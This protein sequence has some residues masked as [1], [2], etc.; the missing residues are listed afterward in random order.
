MN[1]QILEQYRRRAFRMPI[2]TYENA[3]NMLELSWC[4]GGD[5]RDDGYSI[6][7][8]RTAVKRLGAH[9]CDEF[10]GQMAAKRTG[11]MAEWVGLND[12]GETYYAN[13]VLDKA[14]RYVKEALERAGEL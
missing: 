1:N 12:A 2:I 11:K 5:M 13:S 8:F 14:P 10:E 6:G 9:P 3:E 7:R 4:L